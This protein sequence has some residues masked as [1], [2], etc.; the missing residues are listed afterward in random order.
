MSSAQERVRA[1]LEAAGLH[2]GDDEVRDIAAG[3]PTLREQVD[4]VNRVSSG[5]A[6]TDTL[7][8][9][10]FAAGDTHELVT[11]DGPVHTIR[12]AAVALREGS[13][14]ARDLV[15]RVLERIDKHDST[16]GAY[17]TV[18]HDSALEAAEL[19]DAELASG[20]D[21]GPLHGI[22]IAVKDV[23]GTVEAPTRANSRVPAPN[24][25]DGQDATAV[26]RLR[27]AGAVVLGKTTTNEFALGV[28]EHWPDFPM[29]RNPWNTSRYAGGSS[30]GNAIAIAAGLALGA[31]GTDTAGSIRHPAALNGITGL[32]PT[33][34]RVPMSGV[35]PLARTLDTVGPMA[36]TAWDCGL[37]LQAI[38]GVEGGAPE[39]C[40]GSLPDYLLAMDGS[41]RGL[42]IGVP[43]QYF[44]D[45][46]NVAGGVLA[47]VESAIDQL[48]AAGATVVD[49]S[50][51]I[52]DVAKMANHIVLLSEALAYH[53]EALATRWTEYGRP[54]RGL[55]ARGA[56]FDEADYVQAKRVADMFSHEVAEAMKE[57]DVLAM[58]TM[59]AGARLL[60]E[61][62][63]AM[64]DRWSRASF[65]GQWNLTGLPSC[66]LPVGFDER[67]MPV[68]MQLVGRHGDEATVLRVAD[69]YQRLTGFHLAAP[70]DPPA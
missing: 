57:C 7:T 42:R 22:P 68:S 37:L 36:R 31:L 66:A 45:D 35:V 49:V 39:L 4:A 70:L 21:R 63:P 46:G 10:D 19:A 50:L 9:S 5:G 27:S 47:G 26:A 17:V 28:N 60:D 11:A 44:F 18:F 16:L 32:K 34:G 59:P 15:I 38:A 64:M 8:R 30:S 6:I 12:D 20:T 14:T 2:L 56:L 43:R 65:I 1:L 62:D 41:V 13:T 52:A 55:L 53:R 23:I 67:A 40:R 51:P 69:A 58:P 54:L 3:Y 24:W 25:A 33:F 29:P 48:W 61:T